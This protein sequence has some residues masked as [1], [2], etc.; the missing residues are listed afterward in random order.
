MMSIIISTDIWW[1]EWYV[2]APES[3][4]AV[5]AMPYHVQCL[6]SD[7][8][9][10]VMASYQCVPVYENKEPTPIALPREWRICW[11]VFSIHANGEGW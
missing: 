5:T 11:G 10:V 6:I 2:Y 1:L 7:V 3:I 8:L 9:T 4:G